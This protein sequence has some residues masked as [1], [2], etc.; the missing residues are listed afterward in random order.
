M[1]KVNMLGTLSF[2]LDGTLLRLNLGHRGSLFACYMVQFEGLHRRD[3]LIEL[4]WPDLSY[5]RAR[6]AFNTATWRLRK[7]LEIGSPTGDDCLLR[8]GDDLMLERTAH[9]RADT[10]DL[11]WAANRVSELVRSDRLPAEDESAMVDTIENYRGPL[12]EGMDCDWILHE[13]ERLHELCVRVQSYLLRLNVLRGDHE[14]ALARAQRMAAL[15]PLNERIHCELMLLLLLTGRQAEAIRCYERLERT[16][17]ADLAIRPMPETTRLA[18]LIKT[19]DVFREIET[20]T[21][22]RFRLGGKGDCGLGVAA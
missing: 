15:D 17:R 1:L 2:E 9:I 19:G 13:R 3:H 18:D 10:Y 12:L 21:A 8:I 6:A 16:L 22:A 7:L 4:F 20:L 14:L 11:V 5:E